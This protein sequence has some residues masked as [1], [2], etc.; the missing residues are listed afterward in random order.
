MCEGG[1]SQVL[2]SS[3]S[4]GSAEVEKNLHLIF[5]FLIITRITDKYIIIYK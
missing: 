3:F 2:I 4:V 5:V 1:E